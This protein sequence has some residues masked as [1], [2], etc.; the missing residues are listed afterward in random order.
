M[1]LMTTQIKKKSK[2]SENFKN[3][4][5]A[6]NLETVRDTHRQSEFGITSNDNNTTF[7]KI[8]KK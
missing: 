3:H 5:F 1:S 4:K 8:S 7:L 2:F 6:I